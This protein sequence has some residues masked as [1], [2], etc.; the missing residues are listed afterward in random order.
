[1]VLFE[2]CRPVSLRA[3]GRGRGLRHARVVFPVPNARAY[4][5]AIPA[6]SE[7]SSW[8]CFTQSLHPVSGFLRARLWSSSPFQPTPASHVNPPPLQLRSGISPALSFRLGP[9]A[10]AG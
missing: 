10:L 6:Q 8:S 4:L 7:R 9:R 3:A 5:G 2:R 1:D